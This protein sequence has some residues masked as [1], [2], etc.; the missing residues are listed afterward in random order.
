MNLNL[1][2]ICISN[3][4]KNK[5]IIMVGPSDYLI[6]K[7]LGLYIDSFDIVIRIK[8]SFPI[9][10]ELYDDLGRKTNILLSSLKTARVLDINGNYYY[11]NNFSNDNILSMNEQLDFVLFPYPTSLEPFNKFYNQYLN[12]RLIDVMLITSDLFLNEYDDLVLKLNTTPTIFLAGLFYL[13]KYKF[14]KI[15]I[16]GITFQKENY[17]SEYKTIEMVKASQK[18]TLENKKKGGSIH[19]MEKEILFFKNI[20]KNDKRIIIDSKIQDIIKK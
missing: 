9:P 11:Q 7:K 6:G 14:K 12:L 16:I 18:R 4:F 15:Y 20:L 13:L 10:S 5:N 1:E 8:K 19:N 2:Q 3:Y 17:Y